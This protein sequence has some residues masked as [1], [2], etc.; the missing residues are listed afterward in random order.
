MTLARPPNGPGVGWHVDCMA[1]D[2]EDEPIRIALRSRFDSD[3]A[4]SH[5]RA[6][7][8]VGMNTTSFTPNPST[9]FLLSRKSTSIA[10]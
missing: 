8:V 4:P 1:G 6:H 3:Q 7:T 2:V 10:P 5:A 9:D